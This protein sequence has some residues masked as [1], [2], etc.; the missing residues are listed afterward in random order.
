MEYK[1]DCSASLIIEKYSGTDTA[2]I[3]DTVDIGTDVTAGIGT[4]DIGTGAIAGIGIAG[5]GIA[6][7]S[8]TSVFGA[9]FLNKAGT[10]ISSSFPP[11]EFLDKMLVTGIAISVKSLKNP[12]FSSTTAPPVICIP[13]P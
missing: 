5:I 3:A 13:P 2:G 1:S 12:S 4:V 11:R 6:G 8:A 9:N 7:R 10:S